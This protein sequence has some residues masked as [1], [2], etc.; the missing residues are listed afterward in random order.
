M[1]ELERLF[2]RQ[3]VGSF[4]LTLTIKAT[5][6]LLYPEER[7]LAWLKWRL[8]VTPHSNPWWPVLSRYEQIVAGRVEGFGGKI[9][10]SQSGDVPERGPRVRGHPGHGPGLEE[11]TG[12]I[13]AILYDRFGDFEG[14]SILTTSGHER[15]FR[16]REHRVEALVTRAWVERI[17]VTIVVSRDRREQPVRILLRRL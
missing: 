17:T 8:T 9:P 13:A 16:G 2:W 1:R 7:L 14:F 15:H 5:D 6:Q 11:Y 10:P 3:I 4:Q 12:K